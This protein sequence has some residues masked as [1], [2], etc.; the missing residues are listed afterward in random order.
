MADF[1]H[2]IE[3]KVENMVGVGRSEVWHTE[4]QRLG[5]ARLGTVRRP[6]ETYRIQDPR[7]VLET[8]K[9]TGSEHPR[10]VFV[11]AVCSSKVRE[12]STVASA[13]DFLARLSI[14]ERTAFSKQRFF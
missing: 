1:V 13:T 8:C 12:D 2:R 6:A 4:G 14:S 11:Y 3:C 9:L 5:N 7:S 10:I